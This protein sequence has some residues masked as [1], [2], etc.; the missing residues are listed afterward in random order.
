MGDRYALWVKEPTRKTWHGF[1]NDPPS[2]TDT[3]G[4]GWEPS[5]MVPGDLA[6]RTWRPR[7]A[8]VGALLLVRGGRAIAD[9]VARALQGAS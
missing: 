8:A 2:A 6:G 5:A 4:C 1:S 7:T 9:R 3:A